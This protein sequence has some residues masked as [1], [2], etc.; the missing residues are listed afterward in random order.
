[1]IQT[2]DYTIDE[3][4]PVPKQSQP[5]LK[6]ACHS[7]IFEVHQKP[8]KTFQGLKEQIFQASFKIRYKNV[9]WI[10]KPSQR[11]QGY[12]SLI[13]QNPAP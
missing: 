7:T 13:L 11:Y 2:V 10:C 3:K 5:V 1:M 8:D 4:Y 6:G 9:A 12:S